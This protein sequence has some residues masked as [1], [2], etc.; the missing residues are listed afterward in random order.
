MSSEE[1][2]ATAQKVGKLWLCSYRVTVCEQ[3]DRQTDRQTY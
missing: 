1:D 2:R 3:T